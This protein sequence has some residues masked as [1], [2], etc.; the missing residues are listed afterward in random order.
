M[1]A[2][3]ELDI[4]LIYGDAGTDFEAMKGLYNNKLEK[5]QN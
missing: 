4:L 1:K 2:N 3:I 5:Y